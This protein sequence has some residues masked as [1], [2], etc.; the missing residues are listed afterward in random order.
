MPWI[1]RA[2]TD[3]PHG[4]HLPRNLNTTLCDVLVDGDEWQCDRCDAVWVVRERPGNLAH[5]FRLIKA[6]AGREGVRDAALAEEE[7]GTGRG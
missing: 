7:A 4:C 3:R 2:R 5:R 1:K 6:R